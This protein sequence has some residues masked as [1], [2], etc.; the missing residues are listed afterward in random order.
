MADPRDPFKTARENKGYQTVHCEGE[1]IPLILGLKELRKTAKDWQ[2]FSNDNPFMIVLHSEAEMRPVRQL[3]I[4]TDPPQHSAYRKLVEPLFR[5][6]LEED[7]QR[8][9]EELVN[10]MVDHALNLDEIEAVN[11]FALVL[12]SKALAILLGVDEAEAVQWIHWGIHV[13]TDG[14]G[15]QK[16]SDLMSYIKAR[17][18]QAETEEGNFFSILNEAK[19]DGPKLTDEEKYGFAN[20]A[21]AGGRDTIINTVSSI[22]AYIAENKAALDFLRQDAKHITTATEEFVR[23]VSPLTAITRTCPH[24]TELF[25]TQV[26]TGKR[27]ALCWSSANRDETIF[28]H[29]DEIILDRM[30]NPHVGFGFG[31][32]NCLGAAHARLLIRT[33]LKVFCQKIDKIEFISAKE[34]YEIESSFKRQVGYE[35]IKLRFNK[36]VE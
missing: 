27:L 2:N 21:F 16:G 13:F 7:Y 3:P 26:D 14:D 18:K 22:I 28:K 30:P 6:P 25:D 12:Q 34:K 4:E 8:K 5:R 17:F 1:E 9:I 10:D 20:L 33:L 31:V 11:D 35:T 32:H 29:A 19:Y 23:F 36:K 15:E 24:A